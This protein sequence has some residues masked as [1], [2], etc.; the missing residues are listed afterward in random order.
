MPNGAIPTGGPTVALVGRSAAG[1]V[2]RRRRRRCHQGV[3][4]RRLP[5][6]ALAVM[7]AVGIGGCAAAP[8]AT[9]ALRGPAAGP[10]SSSTSVST[11]GP[12]ALQCPASAP[13][14]RLRAPGA[15]PPLPADPTAALACVT[16]EPASKRAGIGAGNLLP[17]SVAV[18]LARLVDESAPANEAAAGRC[19]PR[20]PLAL[21]RFGYPSGPVDV[22]VSVGCS[23]GAFV[24][25]HDRAYEIS[26]V[27][28]DYLQGA[29]NPSASGLVP[30]VMGDSLRQAAALAEQAGDSVELVG[31]LTD[32]SAAG[33]VLLQYP[34]L[35][36]QVAVIAAAHRSPPCRDGDVALQYVP[37]NAGAGNDFGTM[38]LRNISTSW[39]E[40][41][42]PVAVTGLTAG[43]PV[44]GTVEVA[45]TPG[46]EL[47]PDAAAAVPGSQVA[48]DQLVATVLLSAGYRDDYGGSPCDP[49]WIVPTSWQVAVG[50]AAITVPNGRATAVARP[51]GAGG[52]I[53]CRGRFGTSAVE[54][55]TS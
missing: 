20:S 11:T 4:T 21:T 1:V 19:A 9:G 16:D 55:A 44:T 18:V 53:T 45:V 2:Q 49:H 42:G 26:S 15:D 7:A 23:A 17:A 43:R 28:A 39:C 27:L 36:H 34:T 24:Y 32:R 40:L 29:S 22:V 47:S 52:L 8:P 37:G 35:D 50:T 3:R 5:I 30:D 6:A 54:L 51:P 41:D 10:V 33:T 46:L 48:P 12:A 31:E 13:P 14:V 38:L 25:V